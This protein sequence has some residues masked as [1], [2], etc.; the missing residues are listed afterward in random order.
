MRTD[1]SGFTAQKNTQEGRMTTALPPAGWYD[2]PDRSG[3]LRWWDGTTWTHARKLAEAPPEDSWETPHG[4]AARSGHLEPYPP[5]AFTAHAVP[6]ELAT[7]G[8]RFVA[9]LL[10]G[11]VVLAV[12]MAVSVVSSVIGVAFQGLGDLLASVGTLVGFALVLI[13][14]IM[15]E[16]RLGQSYGRHLAGIK[17]VSTGDGRPI[18]S[19]AA[20][21]R[22]I[23]RGLGA[24]VF[25]LGVL[26]ILWD[27]QRQG[28]HDKAVGSVVVKDGTQRK[29][30]PVTYF[31]AIFD[32]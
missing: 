5:A 16:G 19:P 7:A 31:R 23:I 20:L 26:W 15:G 22:T 6:G 2:D 29:L 17:V 28:W 32:T 3:E 25:L 13:S 9:A 21:G 8:D 30:D 10:E 12:F 4:V 14:E 18:G 1:A 27:P 11:V 24:Y